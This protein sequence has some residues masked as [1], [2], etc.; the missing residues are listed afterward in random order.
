MLYQV[1]E[2]IEQANGPV[3]LDELSRRLKIEAGALEGMIAFWVRKG[4]LKDTA[5]AG[6]GGSG[7][8]CTCSAHPTGCVFSHAGPRVI[9]LLDQAPAHGDRRSTSSFRE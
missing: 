3:S 5:V 8:G 7:R 2:A 4:R 1:L 6:C 9:T